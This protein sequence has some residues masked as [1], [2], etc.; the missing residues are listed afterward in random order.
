MADYTVAWLTPLYFE[1]GAA[2]AMFDEYHGVPSHKAPG[3]TIQYHLGRMGQHNVAIAG[4]PA[5]EVGIS[6]AASIAAELMRD[7]PNLE[8]GLLVGI[9]AG[10]PSAERDVR[11]GDVVVAVPTGNNSGVMGY[12]LVNIEPEE[13]VLKQWQNASHPSLRSAITNIRARSTHPNNV[14][15]RGNGFLSDLEKFQRT[16]F[17]RPL[18]GPPTRSSPQRSTRRSGDSPIVHYGCI[19]SGNAVIKSAKVRDAM[20]KPNKAVASE[21][22]A[23]G[24]MNRLPVPVIRGTSDFADAEK[25]DE[26][27]FYAEATAAAYAK[28]LTL[29]LAP[30]SC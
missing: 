22:E 13:I 30:F 10:I 4:F 18:T 28:K 3:Q 23:A 26:W 29:S 27:Q 7:F 12:D 1:A 11:L 25:N 2:L 8:V 24:M 21:M 6:V 17:E 5:G 15:L 16:L 20:S 14:A 19:L 9:A